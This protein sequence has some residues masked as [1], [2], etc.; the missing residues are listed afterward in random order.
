MK[1]THFAKFLLPLTGMS[2]LA[3]PLLGLGW[4]TLHR[5]PQTNL[6]KPLFRGV[7]YRREFRRSP[8]PIMLH[9]VTVDLTAPGIK[10]LVT[11]SEK[12]SIESEINARTTSEFLQEFG[13]QVAINASFFHPFKEVTPWDF[14]PHPGDRVAAVGQAI[15]NG[16]EYSA[17][18]A[19]WPVLCISSQQRARILAAAQCPAQTAQGVAGSSLVAQ[20]GRVIPAP[21]GTADSDGNYSRTAVAVDRTGQRLW[22]L[23]VDD[24]Q[25]LYSEGV[26]LTELG[27]I[28][29]AEGAD[30]AINLDG[31]G[32]TTLVTAQAKGFQLLNAPVHTKIPMRERPVANHLGI[33]ALPTHA[34]VP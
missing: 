10:L 30:A 18:L 2:L 21:V 29:I 16:V 11:P 15:A 14:Y 9:I 25:W 32:S 27:E 23:A 5:P 3:M 12:R 17:P 33:Y 26:T 34:S 19:A 28:A 31:G 20:H 1:R 24:K 8:R 4:F 13:V 22:I 6:E 7:T